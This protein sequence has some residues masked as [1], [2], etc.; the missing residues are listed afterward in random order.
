MYSKI[1]LFFPGKKFR[2]LIVNIIGLFLVSLF[3]M[4]GVALVL[5]LVNL[6]TGAPREGF[7]LKVSNFFGNPDT[8]TLIIIF[9]LTLVA[10]FVLK[11]VFSLVVRRWSLSFLATQQS[12]VSVALLNRYTREP[13]L[14]HRKRGA[15]PIYNAVNDVTSQAYS[16]YVGGV[17]GFIGELLS[18]LM[19]MVMLLVVMPVPALLAMVY[20]G[21]T[22]FALQSVLK[23]KNRE[24]GVIVLNATRGAWSA[25]IESVDSF[26]EIRLYDATDRYMYRYQEK[27]LD[28]VAAS[29]RSAFL[30]EFPK[31]TLEII[32]ILGIAGLLAFMSAT[33]GAD[34]T[35]Y[36]I[37][38]AGA[39]IRI[40]P[41]YTRM[42]ASL[43]G[44]RA[45]EHASDEL[46]KEIK[47]LSPEARMFILASKPVVPEGYEY[48]NKTIEPINIQVDN[49]SFQ[50]PD[51]DKPVLNDITLDIPMG[52]SIAF[53][54]GSGSGKTT[55]IDLILGLIDPTHGQVL[56]NGEPI[57][58]D[59]R[60]WHQRI[61]YV[62]QDVFI[63]DCTVTE[64]V[65]FGLE[66]HEIDLE[67]VKYC[68]EVAALTEVVESLENGLDTKLGYNATRLSGGQK[69]R[70]GIARA[71]Y[72][73][74]SVLILDEATS[75]LDNET[76]HKITKTIERISKDITV[77]IVAH[78]LSTVRNVDQL[79][80]L[81]NGQ[82]ANQGTFAEVQRANAEFANLVKLGQLPD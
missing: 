82:I 73:N 75:A 59:L 28:S 69:Q 36:L 78:R 7:I 9:G 25:M 61:G 32:F 18:I 42:V 55:L 19:L 27:R 22:S 77:I 81:S 53:V 58:K 50:Y 43:G 1:R 41:N 3:E 38:F 2:L 16:A 60:S 63:A 13:Y 67:R 15:A 40:L 31:Y 57:Q 68:L 30:S 14:D 11:G 52:S 80:Y 8:P 54:G 48:I 12:A 45:G 44:I 72:R 47:Q 26:R 17:L 39:C 49:L 46:V 71:L 65:A 76:E 62:P 56:K 20:F 37:L 23:R 6:A 51:G 34:S 29:M 21:L 4:L 74:P 64:A 35:G 33:Q 10:A 24:Q 5:P 79:V 70:M 66:P